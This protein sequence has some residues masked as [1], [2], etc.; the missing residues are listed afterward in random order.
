MDHSDCFLLPRVLRTLLR[1]QASA[2]C[3]KRWRYIAIKLEEVGQVVCQTPSHGDIVSERAAEESQST[4]NG[5]STGLQWPAGVTFAGK[6]QQVSLASRPP[7]LRPWRRLLGRRRDQRCTN[8]RFSIQEYACLVDRRALRRRA[9]TRP[10][11]SSLPLLSSKGS[12][13][14]RVRGEVP[15]RGAQERRRQWPEH[16]CKVKGLSLPPL[17]LNCGACLTL[18]RAETFCM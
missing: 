7:A 1:L 4:M 18:P 5:S 15:R 11:K 2:S 9:A 17:L 12:F 14:T 10:A 8:V 16:K 3:E 6:H 13:S